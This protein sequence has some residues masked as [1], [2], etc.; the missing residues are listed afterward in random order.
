MKA[1]DSA[2]NTSGWTTPWKITIDNTPKVENPICLEN[3]VQT[4]VSNT[5]TMV[6][7]NP[8]ILIEPHPAYVS[9]DGASWIWSTASSLDDDEVMSAPIG[10]SVFVRTFNI[11][12]TP[13]GGSLQIAADNTYTVMVNDSPLATGTSATDSD[14]FTA[15]DTWDIPAELLETGSNTITFTVNN[16]E[17]PENYIGVN[18]AGLLYKITLNVNECEVPEEPPTEPEIVPNTGE[19]TNPTSNQEVSGIIILTA[20]Y[21]DGDDVNDDN[22]Q[23]AVR[24]DSC[25]TNNVFGNVNGFNNPFTW[26]GKNFSS[27]L[28]TT[29]LENGTYCFVFNP[30][31]DQGENDVRET[32][33][34][35]INNP[36][37]PPPVVNG[38]L[39]IK[40]IVINNENGIKTAGD[41]SFKIN[42]GES[43]YFT[44]NEGNPLL[45]EYSVS[46]AP[47]VYTITEDSVANYA[48]ASDNCTAVVV[49]E[50]QTTTCTFTND[51]F[52]HSG[53]NAGPTAFVLGASTE[54][55]TTPETP[56]TEEPKTE[57]QVLGDTTCAPYLTKYM[58]YKA[59]NDKNEVTLLQKFLNEY[60]ALDPKLTEDGIFG[61]STRNAVIAFQEKHKDE[62]L[63][64]WIP[65]GLKGEKGTGNVYKTTLRMVNVLK[66]S[67]TT[68]PMP[69]LP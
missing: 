42:G 46:V 5:E 36:V 64:P 69:Q 23:W 66:C 54:N 43:M 16:E 29:T 12:G 55:T 56:T 50:E 59:N 3:A 40:K 60:L 22:V 33:M 17:K 14:N 34:F 35:T 58:R 27:T 45:G 18:P 53:G 65:F 61:L 52:I 10:T 13:V 41:F 26:D 38:T 62:V 21:D 47:G 63:K 32:V 44:Q 28:D 57:G 24:R 9:I 1:T 7:E 20:T 11:A 6:G 49:S 30:T 67:D 25:S 2:N 37:V 19:I 68:I 8:A 15:I 51:D 31:D 39:L 48:P 4:I